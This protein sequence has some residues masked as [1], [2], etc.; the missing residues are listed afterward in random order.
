MPTVGKNGGATGTLTHGWWESQSVPA[1]WK[2]AYKFL[3]RLSTHL[4]YSLEILLL[5]LHSI[6][7]HPHGYPKE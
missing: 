1:L 5:S 4:P 6:E 7:M 3:T 2:T